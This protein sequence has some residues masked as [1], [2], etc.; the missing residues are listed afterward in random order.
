VTSGVFALVG[1]AALLAAGGGLVSAFLSECR[2]RL[3]GQ[4]R[5]SVLPGRLS[6]GGALT[7]R[8]QNAANKT[9]GGRM[10]LMQPSPEAAVPAEDL[11]WAV[12][13]AL[14]GRR[15]VEE[16]QKRI[17]PAESRNTQFSDT[18]GNDGVETLVVTP[19]L[20]GAEH[21]G[22]DPLP[23]GQVWGISPGGPDEGPSAQGPRRIAGGPA[24]RPGADSRVVFSAALTW[25][26]RGGGSACGRRR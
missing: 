24:G 9:I 14:E 3:Q 15:R 23:P 8:D 18:L 5:A 13:L 22:R 1:G 21:I 4:G 16:Q 2:S 19:E 7:G 26:R 10:K 6:Y 11:E 17:G 12:R 25:G 20:Q